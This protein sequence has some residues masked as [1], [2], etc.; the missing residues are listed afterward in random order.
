L[1]RKKASLE[2][3]IKALRKEQMQRMFKLFIEDDYERKNGVAA[4]VVISALVGEGYRDREIQNYMKIK[5]NY[6]ES[7]Q[8]VK[9]FSVCSKR[10]ALTKLHLASFTH[11]INGK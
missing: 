5:K 11:S 3:D 10:D 7:L 8:K 6:F 4:E 1:N 9:F 2:S